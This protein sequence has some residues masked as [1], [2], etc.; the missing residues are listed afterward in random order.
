MENEFEYLSDRG[1]HGGHS[2]E[3]FLRKYCSYPKL[4]MYNLID[5][6]VVKNKIVLFTKNCSFY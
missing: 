2:A 4:L 1:G 5:V 3:K 6:T